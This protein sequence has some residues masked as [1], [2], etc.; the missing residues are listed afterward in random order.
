MHSAEWK[1]EK[2]ESLKGK[3]IGV[4]GSG[5]SAVQIIP[6]LAARMDASAELHCYQRKP[7]W[8]SPRTQFKFPE[9]VKWLFATVPLL[10]WLF[11]AAIFLYDDIRY[12]GM[13]Y[14]PNFIRKVGKSLDK[15]IVIM[16]S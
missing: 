6:S 12:C 8:I 1:A 3:K 15:Q 2:V 14:P 5:A 10:M 9:F 13:M 16:Y 11:R 4:I 7:A